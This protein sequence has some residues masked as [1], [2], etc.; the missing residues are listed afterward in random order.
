MLTASAEVDSANGDITDFYLIGELSRQA[1]VNCG[2][3]RFY[4]RQG[5]LAPARHGR[6]RVFEK[7]DADWLKYIIELRNLGLPVKTI[8]KL[9]AEGQKASQHCA[10]GPINT[11]LQ[12]HK[13]DLIRQ[14]SAINGQLRAVRQKLG[15]PPEDG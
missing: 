12:K 9:L 6:F 15:E 1:G 2:A 7:Q 8:R 13:A 10:R 4:E 5:L 3:I 14:Q 11:I